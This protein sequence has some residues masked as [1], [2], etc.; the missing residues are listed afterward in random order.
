[1][2]ADPLTNSGGALIAPG[3]PF[4]QPGT[5]LRPPQCRKHACAPFEAAERARAQ[6]LARLVNHLRSAVLSDADCCER[7][8][9]LYLDASRRYL[10]EAAIGAGDIAN[11]VLRPRNILTTGFRLGAR[12]MILAHNHPSNDCRPS[13]AD[14]IATRRL[15]CLGR[16]VDLPLYDHLIITATAVYSMRAKGLL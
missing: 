9:V 3:S 2:L 13:Q 12:G 4:P 7:A 6:S 5:P 1:M 15:A 8:H 10:G 16:M 11:L 14:M